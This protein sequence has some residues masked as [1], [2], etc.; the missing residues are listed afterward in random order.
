[1]VGVPIVVEVEQRWVLPNVVRAS[2]LLWCCA[3]ASCTRFGFPYE[4]GAPSD[5]RRTDAPADRNGAEQRDAS[6]DASGQDRAGQDGDARGPGEGSPLDL[7][8]S[9]ADLGV[10]DLLSLPDFSSSA[11]SNWATPIAALPAMNTKMVICLADSPEHEVT[12]CSAHS[13]CYT[14]GG[15]ELCPADVYRES[16]GGSGQPPAQEDA[17]IAGCIGSAQAPYRPTNSVC[18]PC[19]GTQGPSAAPVSWDCE[20]LTATA[21]STSKELGLVTSSFCNRVGENVVETKGFWQPEDAAIAKAKA[22]CCL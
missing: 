3:L 21:N 10:S 4:V 12:Q 11:C 18:S 15:W 2:A 13:L 22:A 1:M 7:R 16:F 20:G 14:A 6:G 17:W 8:V 9:D 19:N 5:A